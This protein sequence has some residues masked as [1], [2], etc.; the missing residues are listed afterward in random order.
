MKKNKKLTII[1]KL[2]EKLKCSLEE[3]NK[4]SE[5]QT[6]YINYRTSQST[7]LEACAGG[8]KTEVIGLK[9]AYEIKRWVNPNGGLAIITFT[10]SAANELDNRVKKYAGIS[11]SLFPHFIGTFDSWLHSYLLQPFSH[12]LTRYAGKDG[13]KSIRIILED[14][15]AGFLTNYTVNLTRGGQSRPIRATQYYCSPNW[16][17]FDSFD[18]DISRLL[19]SQPLTRGEIASLI[20]NKKKFITAGFATYSDA[21]MVCHQLL[22]AYP[23]LREKISARFPIIFIDEC[24]DLSHSQIEILNILKSRGVHLHFIGDLHQAIYDFR[25]VDP[26]ETRKYVDEHQF[27]NLKLT[28]N[29][30]SCQQIVDISNTVIGQRIRVNANLTAISQ[31]PCI[32]WQYDDTSF[33]QLPTRFDNLVAAHDLSIDKCAILARGKSTISPL[34]SQSGKKDYS[35]VELF[36]AAI[37]SWYKPSRNATDL[38]NAL[39]YLGRFFC[40]LGYDGNGSFREQYRPDSFNNIQ[41]RQLLKK[42]LCQCVDLYPFEENGNDINWNSW[43]PKLKTFLPTVWHELRGRTK[44]FAQIARKIRVPNGE[45]NN[46]VKSALQ[47]AVIENRFRTT[48]IHSVKG[49][50]LD[51]VLLVS[52]KNRLSK[53]GH[54]SHWLRDGNHEEEHIRFAYVAC[55]RPKHLLV[56]ATPVLSQDELN[57]LINLGFIYQP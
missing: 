53:G 47:N 12:Y 44:E 29:Y 3:L 31:T 55:S 1:G 2:S 10:N 13:D 52:H 25:K 34:K 35:K 23:D 50:T 24:Q 9:T 36:V 19:T 56:I 38:M 49:E 17:N 32:I 15:H 42:I 7:F 33:S 40:M 20:A 14:K 16:D 8:G 5:Q 46:S 51:A 43:I 54:F 45:G 6:N 41:W 48:T 11:A 26:S 21:E 39:E 18:E 57:R 27:V 30:R 4:L 28:N 22:S 37:E